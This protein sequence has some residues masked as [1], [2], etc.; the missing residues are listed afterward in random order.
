ME[1]AQMKPLRLSKSQYCKGIKCLKNVWLYNH[2]KELADEPS[3]FQAILF[4]QG[5]EVGE[6]ATSYFPNGELIDE[7]YKDP[8]GAIKH[9][10]EAVKRKVPAIFEAAFISENIL[11]RVDVLRM[12]DDGSVDLIEVKSTSSLKK[13]HYDDVLEKLGYKVRSS[14]LMHLN[15]KYLRKGDL[16]VKDLFVLEKLGDELDAAYA[17][18]PHELEM[19]W[20]TLK[21]TKDP[22][23]LI[24][25]KCN[26]PYECE[27]KGHCWKDVSGASIHRLTRISDK[28]RHQL[29]DDGLE[30][31]TDIPANFK[32][33]DN[34]SIQVKA[35]KDK[36]PVISQAPIEKH[37]KELRF[38]LYFFDLE[39]VSFAIPPYDGTYSYLHLPFQ[40][41]VH[42]QE[43]EEAQ[44]SQ[45][46]FLHTSNTDPRRAFAESLCQKIGDSGSVIVYHASYE[47]GRL[48]HLAEIFPDLA[49]KFQNIISRLWDL[50]TP[51]AKRWYCDREFEGSSS[52]KKVLPVFVPEL[53]YDDLD[54]QNG[55][56][57]GIR[58]TEMISG[59]TKCESARDALLKYCERDTLAMVRILDELLK[60]CPV[61]VERVA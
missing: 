33:S 10:L 36:E 41:S 15:K 18:I 42:I 60:I 2:K 26:N 4:K 30:L 19:I 1:I 34:Q 52:I 13:Q 37:L 20:A 17:K 31:L 9:T 40:Y 46:E 58:Y 56:L 59:N 61:K 51:F 27:F 24:G 7:G 5:Q 32:L 57:A 50:E 38:P 44:V 54:I 29:L 8:E 55:A 35:T 23:E 43:G 39:S 3:E 53:S 14:F 28:K 11:I 12:N 16:S 47:R 48:E 25:S 49:Q 6:L 22:D 21:H 45:T